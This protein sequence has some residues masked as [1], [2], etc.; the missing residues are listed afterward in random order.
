MVFGSCCAA[1]GPVLDSPHL[2]LLQFAGRL[3]LENGPWRIE[4]GTPGHKSA[5]ATAANPRA[6]KI[7]QPVP[8]TGHESVST[9]Q[10]L[11]PVFARTRGVQW[12]QKVGKPT[13]IF[14]LK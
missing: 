3:K 14:N 4:I 9:V 12:L 2:G 11:L 10:T 5:T 8:A 1:F 6:C 13:Q 7:M